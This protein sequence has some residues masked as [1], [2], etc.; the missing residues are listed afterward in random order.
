MFDSFNCLST[1]IDKSLTWKEHVN[2][3]VINLNKANAILSKLRL[4]LDKRRQSTKQYLNCIY[5]MFHLSRLKTLN[6]S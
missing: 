6:Q 2:E 4:V 3:V 1:R 5:A